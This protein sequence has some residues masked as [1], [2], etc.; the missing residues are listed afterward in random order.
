MLLMQYTINA[1]PPTV[2]CF[3]PPVTIIK[4]LLTTNLV[5]R[6]FKLGMSI[7]IKRGIN[8]A[9][10]RIITRKAYE[11][12]TF[13]LIMNV[14]S[15]SAGVFVTLNLFTYFPYPDSIRV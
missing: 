11:V 14:S 1:K 4:S 9:S 12:C 5:V 8:I 13:C 6:D 7:R 15:Y 10:P 2:V 3:V